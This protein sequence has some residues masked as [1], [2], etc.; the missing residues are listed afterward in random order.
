MNRRFF[1]GLMG[2]AATLPF[3]NL[4]PVQREAL[5][6]HVAENNLG[7]ITIET[8]DGEVLASFPCQ[9]FN[10]EKAVE[11]KIRFPD[12][13]ST[14]E[15]TGVAERMSF[16]DRKGDFICD[17]DLNLNT[18]CICMGDAIELDAEVGMDIDE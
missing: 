6:S 5:Q 18:N 16:Y 1:M 8:A 9:E 15:G 12:L 7:K 13:E 3:I 4:K 11:G 10:F 17:G 2:G 14:A